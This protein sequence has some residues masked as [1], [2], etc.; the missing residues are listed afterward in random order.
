M[1]DATNGEIKRAAVAFAIEK[2]LLDMGTATLEKVGEKLHSKY[3]AYF[4]DCYE[5]PE[6]LNYILKDLYGKCHLTI[7][8]S[9][10]KH[11]GELASQKPI[12]EFLIKISE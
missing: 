6:Y 10:R 9:I 1:V 7:V 11:L 5:H 8:E 2:A 4:F 3:Q 12:E